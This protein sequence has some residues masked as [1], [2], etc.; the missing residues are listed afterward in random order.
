MKNASL[1]VVR[2]GA[3]KEILEWQ[4][5]FQ[6]DC[7]FQQLHATCGYIKKPVRCQTC[8]RSCKVHPALRRTRLVRIRTLALGVG[9][10]CVNQWQ[11]PYD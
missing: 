6:S 9:D 4:L 5:I 3:A 7:E 10:K 11:R 8:H 1:Q 2:R